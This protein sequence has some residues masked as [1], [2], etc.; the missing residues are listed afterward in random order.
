MKRKK[1]E[2]ILYDHEDGRVVRKTYEIASFT[3]V[4]HEKRGFWA[5]ILIDATK[6]KET[7]D[8]TKM[9]AEEEE[10]NEGYTG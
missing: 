5:K 9:Y 6:L 10:R 4:P 1:M 8:L 3:I 2:L 7:V